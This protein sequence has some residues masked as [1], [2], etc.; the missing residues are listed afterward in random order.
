[1][2]TELRALGLL[3]LL[4]GCSMTRVYIGSP[5]RDDPAQRVKP[6]VTDRGE[7]L[8]VFGAP[9][10][11]LRHPKGDVFIY[12]FVRK[13]TDTLSLEEPVVTNLEIFSYSRVE[14]KEDRLVILFGPEG[15]VRA[16]GMRRGTEDLD[17]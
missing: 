9:D 11:I 8:L 17:R 14:E 1:M 7:V 10:R 12:R 5:I 16:W 4:A 3:L 6:G 13:N 2:R 15:V